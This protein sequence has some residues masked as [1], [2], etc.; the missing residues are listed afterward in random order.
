M[1]TEQNIAVDS[2]TI[3]E[4]ILERICLLEYPPGAMMSENALATE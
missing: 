2:D 4:Q 3:Y 1:N